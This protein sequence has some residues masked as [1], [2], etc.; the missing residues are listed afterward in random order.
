MR[1][2]LPTPVSREDIASML[3]VAARAPS[4]SNTQPWK[5]Y[6]LMGDMKARLTAE[7]LAVYNDKAQFEALTEDYRYYPSDWSSPYL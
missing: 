4:G 5:A 3:E 7:I 2:Y 1:A 6:V